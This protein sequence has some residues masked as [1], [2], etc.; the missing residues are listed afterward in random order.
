MDTPLAAYATELRHRLLSP[1]ADAIL[2]PADAPTDQDMSTALPPQYATATIR[3]ETLTTLNPHD[4][5]PFIACLNRTENLHAATV[6]ATAVTADDDPDLDAYGTHEREQRIE[7]WRDDYH[8]FIR[9]LADHHADHLLYRALPVLIH[10]QA[11]QSFH[12]D[13]LLATI[14]LADAHGLDTA[15]LITAIATNDQQDL[16]ASLLTEPD[17][18]AALRARADAWIHTHAADPSAIHL[19]CQETLPTADSND[20]VQTVEHTGT[21]TDV[22]RLNPTAGFHALNDFPYTNRFRPIPNYPG[23]DETIAQYAADLRDR[24]EHQQR[25]L[26]NFVGGSPT[27]HTKHT[28]PENISRPTDRRTPPIAEPGTR[29]KFHQRNRSQGTSRRRTRRHI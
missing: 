14:A 12:Y 20:L 13:Q 19:N 3:G 27:R 24:I 26:A 18:A 22:L 15:S 11:Q 25:E 16:G 21:R 5:I 17:P 1:T 9:Q 23:R 6:D 7:R 4:S 10:H 29:T 8:H 2:Q 28:A